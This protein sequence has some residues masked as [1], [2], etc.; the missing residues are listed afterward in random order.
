MELEFRA[1][2]EGFEP[3]NLKLLEFQQRELLKTSSHFSLA[4]D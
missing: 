3:Q 1:V 4:T 2:S